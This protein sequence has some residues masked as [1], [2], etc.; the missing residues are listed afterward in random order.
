MSD[1]RPVTGSKRGTPS[2][3]SDTPLYIKQNERQTKQKPHVSDSNEYSVS[4]SLNLST[5]DTTLFLHEGNDEPKTQVVDEE[6]E[7]QI[8]K[9]VSGILQQP[10]FV[11]KISE[12]VTVQMAHIINNKIE[13]ECTKRTEPLTKLVNNQQSTIKNLTS[14]IETLEKELEEQQQY[15]RRTSL[16]FNNVKLPL[17]NNN[18]IIYPIDTDSLV[19][20][21]CNDQLSQSITIDDIGRTHTIGKIKEGKASIIVRF[22]SYRKRQQVYSNKKRLRNH[23]DKLNISENLTRQRFAL[24]LKLNKHRKRGDI[25]SYWTQDG[26]IIV[27]PDGNSQP[28]DFRTIS[29]EAEIQSVLGLTPI[30]DD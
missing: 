2:D 22:L 24:I 26:R 9:I 5:N 14:R 6:T 1:E 8:I 20:D 19:L 10:D 21:V 29:R 25:D 3:S 27:K 11:A 7:A 12:I 28:K 16:R 30:E 4:G 13:A 17:D 15:S 23:P 18:K